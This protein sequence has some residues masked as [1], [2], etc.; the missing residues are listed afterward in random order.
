[1]SW[2]DDLKR[3]DMNQ[4]SDWP[5]WFIVII[6]FLGC[7][8]LVFLSWYFLLE[9]QR[10]SLASSRNTEIELRQSFD[11]KKG[12]V[13]NLP[14][15][16]KQMTEIEA[17]LSAMLEK[18]PDSSEVP[19]LLV[20]ITEAGARRGLEFVVFDPQSQILET[21]YASLPILVE[22]K[23]SYHKIANFISDLAQMPRIV[24][25]GEMGL[26]SGDDNRVSASLM[27]QTYSYLPDGF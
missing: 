10:S 14:A 12:M 8:I 15:Y 7:L 1:M 25:V 24:T 2:Q 4:Q 27:L 13:V 17:L 6:S 26:S 20:N 9:G 3:V 19:S 18:L 16:K 5:A 22:V 23:G 11:V 21:F